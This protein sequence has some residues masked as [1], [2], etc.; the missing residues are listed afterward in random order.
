MNE[1]LNIQKFMDELTPEYKKQLDESFRAMRDPDSEDQPLMRQR[2]FGG[3]ANFDASRKQ[4]ELSGD[5][6]KAD[7]IRIAL[8]LR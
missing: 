4:V 1:K 7:L 5:F 2:S 3:D 8:V 6:S